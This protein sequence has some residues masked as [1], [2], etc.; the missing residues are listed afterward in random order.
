MQKVSLFVVVALVA[1]V[2]SA[3]Q[4]AAQSRLYCEGREATIV[5][6]SGNDVLIGTKGVDVFV[7]MGG[8]DQ[9][10]GRAGDDIICAGSGDDMIWGNNGADLIYGG[11]GDDLIRGNKGKD[12]VF[13]GE[14]DDDLRGG[15]HDDTVRGDNDHDQLRGGNGL[16][17]LSGDQ[18]RDALFGDNGTDVLVADPGEIADGGA[19]NDTVVEGGRVVEGSLSNPSIVERQGAVVLR[20]PSSTPA[21]NQEA[22]FDHFAQYETGGVIE[23]QLL[24]LLND[25][26]VACGL[27]PLALEPTLSAWSEDWSAQ[28]QAD[29]ANGLSPWLRHSSVWQNAQSLGYFAAGENVAWTDTQRASHLHTLVA[30]GSHLCNILSP[31]FDVVGIG[32]TSLEA[33]GPGIIA[34]FIFA[35]D[36]SPETGNRFDG[37]PL[38]GLESDPAPISCGWR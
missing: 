30:S 2:L 6:T 12:L 22:I 38:A 19:G 20:A 11:E 1:A 15:R 28:L 10:R 25:T 7:A 5:G 37:R 24:L 29:R 3:A 9:I 8:D 16:D 13:G 18:G 33:N 17:F 34:T 27:N 32:A 35:G 21:C 26:R 31:N 4:L 14:G 23:S 36:G